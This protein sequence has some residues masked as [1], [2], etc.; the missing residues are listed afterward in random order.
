MVAE[1]DFLEL[2]DGDVFL[3]PGAEMDLLVAL[4]SGA[5]GALVNLFTDNQGYCTI[6]DL[7]IATKLPTVFPPLKMT[8]PQFRHR[9]FL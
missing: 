9:L 5:P 2:F 1:P 4:L 8:A 7:A 3:I 6:E